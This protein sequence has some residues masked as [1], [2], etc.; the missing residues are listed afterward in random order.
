MRKQDT[1]CP[2][3][4]QQYFKSFSDETFSDEA[5]SDDGDGQDNNTPNERDEDEDMLSSLHGEINLRSLQRRRSMRRNPI[6]F[7]CAT[8]F[9]SFPITLA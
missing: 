9:R 7:M 6:S 5:F 4:N 3:D 1:W 8:D 2:N